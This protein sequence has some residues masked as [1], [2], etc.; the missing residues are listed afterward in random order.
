MKRLLADG[1]TRIFQIA[2][3]FRAA[4]SAGATTPSSRCSSGTAPTPASTDVMSDTEQLVALVTGGR[5]SLGR[6]ARSTRRAAR[7]TE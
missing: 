5:V 1:L 3:C 6:R 2:Q 4:S 7:S